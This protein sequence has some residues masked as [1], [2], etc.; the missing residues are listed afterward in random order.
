MLAS[1]CT[2]FA[3]VDRIDGR[4]AEPGPA[5]EEPGEQEVVG[6]L[7]AVPDDLGVAV[8]QQGAGGELHGQGAFA[9]AGGRGDPVQAGGEPAAEPRVERPE[10]G[11]DDLLRLAAFPLVD[12][13]E[14]PIGPGPAAGTDPVLDGPAYRAV[15]VVLPVNRL[16]NMLGTAQAGEHVV[17]RRTAVFGT[18]D[19]ELDLE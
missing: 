1:R 19:Q 15:Q 7:P 17:D 4:I 5:G 3:D 11:H 12:D 13:R 10:P 9:D 18:L 16:R 6:H 14:E 8:V 2:M